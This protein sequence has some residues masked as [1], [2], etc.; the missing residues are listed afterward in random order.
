MACSISQ[1]QSTVP[2]EATPYLQ[3]TSDASSG[4]EGTQYWKGTLPDTFTTLGYYETWGKP[5]VEISGIPWMI[6]TYDMISGDITHVD[7]GMTEVTYKVLIVDPNEP[8]DPDAQVHLAVDS[9]LD[10]S[11][12][13][14]DRAMSI[15]GITGPIY[16]LAGAEGSEIN[17]GVQSFSFKYFSVDGCPEKWTFNYTS[18]QMT[19]GIENLDPTV[20]FGRQSKTN[21]F[22]LY[23][24]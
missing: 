17:M 6:L 20:Y 24:Q 12:Y 21:A 4:R 1:A 7:V 22:H 23:R 16:V 14:K 8:D 10:D 3:V 5:V 19:G 9:Y 18:D 15:M 11:S 13:W 2:P